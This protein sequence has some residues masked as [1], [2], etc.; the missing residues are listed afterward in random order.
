MNCKPVLYLLA[1]ALL[2][3]GC[4][5]PTAADPAVPGAAHAAGPYYDVRGQLDSL[6]RALDARHAGVQKQVSLRG[7]APETKQVPQV[8]W[9]DELQL[10]YQADINKAAL[11]GAYEVKKVQVGKVQNNLPVG[12][13][14]YTYRRKP[15]YPNASVVLLKIVCGPGHQL[16]VLYATVEQHNVL[17]TS[18]KELLLTCDNDSRLRNIGYTVDGKQKLVFF[19]PLNFATEAQSL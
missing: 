19:D 14:E 16:R 5:K 10:F 2:F 7:S 18:K 4:D 6:V 1:A 3:S 9:A 13:T 12:C 15:G 8:K 11:S 17:F